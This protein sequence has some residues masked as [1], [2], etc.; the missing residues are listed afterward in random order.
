MEAEVGEEMLAVFRRQGRDLGLDRRGNDDRLGAF[1][2]GLLE[3]ARG[4]RIA[5]GGVAFVDVA[6][7]EHRLGGQQLRAL[8]R[9]GLLGILGLGQ[10]RGL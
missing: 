9:L 3:H 7:V 1:R 6:D 4:Q 10:P 5:V 2:G 8:Q